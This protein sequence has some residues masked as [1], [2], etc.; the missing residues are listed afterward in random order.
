[1]KQKRTDEARKRFLKVADT[2]PR[3]PWADDALARTAQLALDAGDHAAALSLARSFP[4]RFPQS[5]FG[6][7]VRLIEARALLA[8][9][10]AREAAEHLE[11][12]LG[13]GKEPGPG[14]KPAASQLA[15]A[16][17]ARARY[18]LALAYR[19]AGRTAQ[20]DAVLASL[21]SSSQEPVSV[22]AQFLIGQEAVEQGHFAEAIGPLRQ[23]LNDNPR[24]EVADSALAHLATAELGLRHTD[25]AWKTLIQLAD[26]FPRSMALAP[27]R[28]RVAEAALDASQFARAAEQFQRILN[29]SSGAAVA[30]AAA[31][32]PAVAPIDAAVLARARVGLGRALWRL[33]KPAE[34][35]TLFAEFLAS[36]GGDPEAPAWAWNVPGAGGRRI[37]GGCVGR[38]H[39]GHRTK[40]QGPRGTSGR[41]GAGSAAGPNRPTGGCLEDLGSLA[42]LRREA[43]GPEFSGRETREPAGR[44]RL[45]PG[46][47]PQDGRIR[48]RF[49]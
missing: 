42:L 49:R 14:S 6:A 43:N 29:S 44:A 48:R 7:D 35:A 30:P 3:D 17:L 8:G 18:D 27:T 2:Y 12:L 25:Q 37:N 28:L 10:Q 23:Y 26:R 5:K 1:M 31:G 32:K 45:G 34:A 21:A 40:P 13:L 33:G 39:P 38:V 11:A 24:G 9:G 41:A 46:R 20:A 36:S 19:A 15:P 4:E 16:A 22:D 47:C